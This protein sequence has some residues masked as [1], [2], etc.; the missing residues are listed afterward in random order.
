MRKFNKRRNVKKEISLDRE[1]INEREGF[2]SSLIF[3]GK[4]IQEYNKSSKIISR[5][6]N[7]FSAILIVFTAVQATAAILSYIKSSEEIKYS[8]ELMSFNSAMTID[9]QIKSRDN[10]VYLALEN[11]L[12][13]ED[14]RLLENNGGYISEPKLD[15][16]L[17]DISLAQDLNEKKIISDDDM[18]FWFAYVFQLAYENQ[19][20]RDYLKLLRTKSTSS[21]DFYAGFED[22]A[23][24]LLSE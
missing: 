15:M 6:Q 4:N 2:N 18:Y 16:Y 9:N 17:N 23:N 19:E 5:S 21:Q 14:F 20:V 7:I 10:E 8:K 24:K 1:P 11:A 13:N 3:L 12:N 22:M